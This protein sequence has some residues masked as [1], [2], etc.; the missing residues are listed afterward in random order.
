MKPRHYYSES[1]N[2]Y[3]DNQQ[4]MYLL[5]LSFFRH[6]REPYEQLLRYTTT[7]NYALPSLFET[8]EWIL[9]NQYDGLTYVLLN[10]FYQRCFNGRYCRTTWCDCTVLCVYV[11]HLLWASWSLRSLQKHSKNTDHL[12]VLWE[13]LLYGTVWRNQKNSI[14]PKADNV[15]FEECVVMSVK[16]M[17][18]IGSS[19]MCHKTQNPSRQTL[20]ETCTVRANLTTLW[21]KV[22]LLQRPYEWLYSW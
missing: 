5:Y 1:L 7:N 3:Y 11:Y 22:F 20:E 17:M 15:C 8:F 13:C 4:P 10:Y 18:I 14:L 19:Q 9:W 2:L 16:W 6:M 12:H 21:S